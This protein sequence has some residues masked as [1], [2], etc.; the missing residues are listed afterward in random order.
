[1][2]EVW[3]AVGERPHLAQ[4]C[5][6]LGLGDA[7]AVMVGPDAAGGVIVRVSGVDD[8]TLAATLA[9]H[10]PA[11]APEP[12]AADPVTIAAATIRDEVAEALDSAPNNVEGLKAA[13]VSGLATAVAMLT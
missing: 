6:E 7:P 10:H 13:I 4:L 2:G 11:P 12:V 5:G 3:A 9:A 1:M 8:A